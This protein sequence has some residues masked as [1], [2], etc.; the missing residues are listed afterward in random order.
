M[1]NSPASPV[2]VTPDQHIQMKKTQPSSNYSERR[3]RKQDTSEMVD[4]LLVKALHDDSQQ[5][6]KKENNHDQD[7]P[8]SLFCRSII[9]QMKQLTPKMRNK[10]RC[11][12]S[13]VMFELINEEQ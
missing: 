8:D 12:I 4:A 7:D 11:K 13:Q 2:P 1:S 10:A 6:G 5:L 3:K 9:G